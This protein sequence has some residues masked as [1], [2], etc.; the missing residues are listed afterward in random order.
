MKICLITLCS[1]VFFGL[2]I[3]Q[4][5]NIKPDEICSFDIVENNCVYNFAD[6]T[7]CVLD[8]TTGKI[9][10]SF[11]LD[12]FRYDERNIFQIS[13]TSRP[14]LAVYGGELMDEDGDH[15]VVDFYD[16]YRGKKISTIKLKNELGPFGLGFSDDGKYYYCYGS[17]N[18]GFYCIDVETG[19]EN[20]NGHLSEYVP[21][22]GVHV[23]KDGC[24]YITYNCVSRSLDNIAAFDKEG[25][26]LWR[27]PTAEWLGP[28][29]QPEGPSDILFMYVYGNEDQPQEI[30]VMSLKDG[31]LLWRKSIGFKHLSICTTTQDR[32]KQ[33]IYLN[34]KMYIAHFPQEQIIEIPKITDICDVVFSQDGSTLYFLPELRRVDDIWKKLTINRIRNSHTLKIVNCSTGKITKQIKLKKPAIK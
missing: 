33:A 23:R 6:G 4:T 10:S 19:V 24:S 20:W 31:S 34:K 14:V 30:S 32:K 26:K 28:S 5:V 3:H 25:E 1:T 15:G 13:K 12:K 29:G 16:L 9:S 17:L 18:W 21:S 8:T 2:S 27:N 7:V 11:K 22:T